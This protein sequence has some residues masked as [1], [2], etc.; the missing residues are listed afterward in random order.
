VAGQDLLQG[1]TVLDFTRVLAGPYCTRLLAD[2]GARVIKVERPRGDD[3]RAA[4]LQLD[5]HRIDQSTYFVRV[6]AGKRSVAL[7]LAHPDAH[8]V[9]LDLVR[10]AD[11]LVES[12]RPGVMARLGLDYPTAAAVRP[13]L[14]YCSISGYGQTGPWRDRPA[15]AHVVHA[16]SGLMHLERDTDERPRILYLQAADVLAGTHA[17]GAVVAA[18]LR[19][20]RTGRGA[21]VDVSML[22][23]LVGAE[24]ISFGSVLNGGPSYPGSRSGMLVHRLGDGWLA[25]QVVGVLD[26]WPRLLALLDRPALAADPR[27]A[28]PVARREHWPE[29]RAI[30]AAWLDRFSSVEEALAALGAARIPCSRVLWPAEVVAAP[31]LAARGAFPAVAHPTRGAVRV[32]APPFQ[33]DG[34]PVAPAGPAPYRPGEDTRAVLAEV[35]GYGPDRIAELARRGAV[36]GPDLAASGSNDGPLAEVPPAG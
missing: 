30:I 8:A 29:L 12:F 17:F 14:V 20:V 26:L 24:D 35:V 33:V 22:E 3:T 9:V 6:N 19:R 25:L 15:F 10:R 36:V 11:V 31:H 27:F 13:D 28:T 34:E 23:A 5:P 16:T 7:D 4:P 21:H 18:L 2:L 32:T 1:V